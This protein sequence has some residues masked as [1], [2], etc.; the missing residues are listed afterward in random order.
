MLHGELQIDRSTDKWKHFHR[1]CV[2]FKRVRLLFVKKPNYNV[3][4][5]QNGCNT[6]IYCGIITSLMNYNSDNIAFY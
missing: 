6:V 1:I 3:L 4:S 5:G 2:I